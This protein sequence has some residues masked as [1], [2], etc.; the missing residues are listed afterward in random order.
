[1]AF[2]RYLSLKKNIIDVGRILNTLLEIK[3]GYIR[4]QLFEIQRKAHV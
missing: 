2:S 3:D 4:E 1:M